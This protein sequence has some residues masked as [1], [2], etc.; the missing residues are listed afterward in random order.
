MGIFISWSKTI[1]CI[2]IALILSLA[3]MVVAVKHLGILQSC[4]YSNKKYL[5]WLKKPNN[6]A[7]SRLALLATCCAFASCVI[8]LCFCFAGEWA[9]IISLVAYVIFIVLYIYAEAKSTISSPS[10]LTARY[11]RLYIVCF[12]VLTIISY[13]VITLL[14]FIYAVC[15]NTLFGILKYCLLAIIPILLPLILCLGNLVDKIYEVPKNA[16]YV[17][18]A[19][20][21]IADSNIRI[22]GVTGSCGK[23]SVKCILSQMLQK[24]YRVLSTPRSYNT[25]QGLALT[26]N[27]ANLDDYD[28][29]IAEMGARHLGDIA[30]LCSI[31]PPDYSVITAICPQH[32][33]SFFSLSNI[34]KG[35]GEIAQHTKNTCFI[36]SGC[37]DYFGDMPCKKAVCNC[38]ENVVC[39]SNGVSFTLKLGGKSVDVASKL[40]GEHSAYNIGLCAMVAYE[41]GVSLNDIADAIASLN[42]VEHRLQLIQSNGVNILDDGYNSNILGAEEAINVLKSFGGKRVVVTPGLVELGV[43]DEQENTALGEK[44]VGVDRVILVGDTLVGFVKNGY[45]SAGGSQESLDIVPSLQAAQNLLKDYITAGDSVLFLNDLPYMY[46]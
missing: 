14:N 10:K 24:K 45:L 40:L 8:S 6:M 18:R 36:S 43:L 38:V 25:P 37:A 42:F 27:G 26:I 7:L 12:V 13:I 28:I 11:K 35:K 34:V 19:K 2:A 30:E 3:L 44:L 23:T 39:S 46:L 21:K 1:E 29:L 22:I 4:G 20:A 31:C 17:K 9:S 32:L 5:K 33:E 16:G 15:G 41:L